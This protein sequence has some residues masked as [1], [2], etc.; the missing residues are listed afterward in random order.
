MVNFLKSEDEA[1]GLRGWQTENIVE[2]E[3]VR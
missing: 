1:N 3:F 2:G